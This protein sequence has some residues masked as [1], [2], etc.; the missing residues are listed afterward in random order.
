MIYPWSH[1]LSGRCLFCHGH[2]FKTCPACHG[3]Q[4]LMHYIQMTVTWCVNSNT[5]GRI[6]VRLYSRLL[7][8]CRKNNVNVFIPDRQ[9]DFPDQNF[10]KVTGEPFFVDENILV[11]SD[12]LSPLCPFTPSASLFLGLLMRVCCL[13]GL[14]PPRVP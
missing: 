1:F 4:N 12:S 5:P 6:R 7:L 9:P 14:P 2:G 13:A 11:K 8:C 3:S 10:E